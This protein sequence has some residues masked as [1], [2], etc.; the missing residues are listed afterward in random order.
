M[1]TCHIKINETQNQFFFKFS[2]LDKLHQNNKDKEILYLLCSTQR[3]ALLTY[4]LY[5]FDNNK[6]KN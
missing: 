5:Y 6:Q 3:E 1:E 2:C 4:S